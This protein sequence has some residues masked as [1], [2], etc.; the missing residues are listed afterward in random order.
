[1]L[2]L[3]LR[4][5]LLRAPYRRRTKRQFQTLPKKM[6]AVL[7]DLS[8]F[9]K[10]CVMRYELDKLHRHWHRDHA[11]IVGQPVPI[12]LGARHGGQQNE[13]ESPAHFVK[14]HYAAGGGSGPDHNEETVLLPNVMP[15]LPLHPRLLIL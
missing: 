7:S 3:G 4:L 9:A 6:L 14:R 10:V 5:D 8:D 1:M 15:L 13:Q 12:F 11:P 2:Q